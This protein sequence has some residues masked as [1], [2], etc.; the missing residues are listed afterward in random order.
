MC[1]S[2]INVSLLYTPA[3]PTVGIYAPHGGPTNGQTMVTFFGDGFSS[4]ELSFY[5]VSRKDVR[6][7]CVFSG[8]AT[9]ATVG[10]DG[11]LLSC[12]SPPMILGIVNLTIKIGMKIFLPSLIFHSH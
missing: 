10:N 11:I 3:A 1:L 12:L 5:F 9:N 7:Y 8:V 6:Y 4:G 2:Y